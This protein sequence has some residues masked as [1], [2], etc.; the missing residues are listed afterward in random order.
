M[1]FRTSFN[2]PERG[3]PYVAKVGK[4]AAH[5]ALIYVYSY[6]GADQPTFIAVRIGDGWKESDTGYY[7]DEEAIE[8]VSSAWP[9]VEWSDGT[10]EEL[11]M[12]V[13]TSYADLKDSWLGDFVKA[14]FWTNYKFDEYLIFKYGN[15]QYELDIDNETVNGVTENHM[16]F[17]C[18]PDVVTEIVWYN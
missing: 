1:Y 17:F 18:G 15:L 16:R 5:N 14:Y 6:T 9:D 10:A 12:S 2:Q 8:T 7:Y 11:A 3:K 4:S 13:V